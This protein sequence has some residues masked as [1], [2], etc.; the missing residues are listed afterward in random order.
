MKRTIQVAGKTDVGLVRANNEDNLGFDTSCGVYIVCDGMG[1]Q[2][3]GER[4]SKIAVDTVMT[5]F[6]QKRREGGEVVGRVFERLSERANALAQAIQIANQN[7]H[8]E[9]RRDPR[10]TGMGSTIVAI[11][12]ERDEFSVAHV[13]DSRA[14]LLRGGVIQQLT[15]DHSLVMEQ[16]RRGLM[17]M[18][19]A[20]KS[21]IQNVIVRSLGAEESVEP[22]LADHELLAGDTL[23]MCS[24][25][26]CHFVHDDV[27]S[28]VLAAS[29]SPDKA[30]EEL[31]QAAKGANSNDNITCLVLHADE[32]SWSDRMLGRLKPGHSKSLESI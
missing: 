21:T 22:D 30:C 18:E 29:S 19:D 16:V 8:E 17:T 3:A 7:I 11:A 2:A 14:Y 28:D 15:N 23:L 9:A 12:I 4:A 25:G 5:Y 20:E 6:R 26:L 10:Y 13:G 27:I 1:G 24:D 31:I 32:P